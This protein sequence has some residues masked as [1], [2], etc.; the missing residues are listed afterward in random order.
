MPCLCGFQQTS[1]WSRWACQVQPFSFQGLSSLDGHFLAFCQEAARVDSRPW[2]FPRPGPF[3]QAPPNSF[4]FSTGFPRCRLPDLLYLYKHDSGA[5]LTLTFASFLSTCRAASAN[6]LATGGGGEKERERGEQRRNMSFETG[7]G[8][9]PQPAMDTRLPRAQSAFPVLQPPMHYPSVPRLNRSNLTPP[10][11]KAPTCWLKAPSLNQR[12]SLPRPKGT[13]R[14]K[15][16]GDDLRGLQC[17]FALSRAPNAPLTD[18]KTQSWPAVGVLQEQGDH[19]DGIHQNAISGKG[20][21]RHLPMKALLHTGS[22]FHPTQHQAQRGP[23]ST[24]L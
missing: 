15:G 10:T 18:N 21:E 11:H 20:G 22:S 2:L 9:G 16:R 17:S 4:S 23:G 24:L 3:W 7:G 19:L 14:S 8:G 12:C 13:Q 1:S 5:L 6:T